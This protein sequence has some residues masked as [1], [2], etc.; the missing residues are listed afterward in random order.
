[1]CHFIDLVQF[2]TGLIDRRVNFHKLIGVYGWMLF[3]KDFIKSQNRIGVKIPKC[4]IE[5]K[6]NICDVFHA[7]KCLRP[8]SSN[9]LFR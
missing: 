1:M 5:V 3:F 9:T 6:K 7:K 8:E 2:P 4:M